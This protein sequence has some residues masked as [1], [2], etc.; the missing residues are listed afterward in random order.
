LALMA[1]IFFLPGGFAD[2]IERRRNYL[3]SKL[4]CGK[5]DRTAAQEGTR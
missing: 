1:L 2:F 3:I 4:R 5:F